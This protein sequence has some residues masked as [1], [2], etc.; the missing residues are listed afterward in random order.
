MIRISRALLIGAVLACFPS[1]VQASTESKVFP[2]ECSPVKQANE[3]VSNA[4]SVQMTSRF[5]RFGL[6]DDPELHVREMIYTSEMA[7]TRDQPFEPW[8]AQKRH[9]IDPRLF[10]PDNCRR[11]YDAVLNGVRSVVFEHDKTLGEGR[12]HYRCKMWVETPNYRPLQS[13]CEGPF[14]YT[15]RWFY[16]PHVSIPDVKAD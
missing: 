12:Q 5:A 11:L 6:G 15:R 4:P 7:Y 2:E 9:P 14:D 10:E 3:W 13:I 16:L 8:R 1:M